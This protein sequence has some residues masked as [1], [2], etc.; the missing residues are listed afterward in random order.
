VDEVILVDDSDA[1]EM[2]RLLAD[3][4]GILVGI[5][6]GANVFGAVEVAKKYKGKKVVTVAPDGID[7]YMSMGLFE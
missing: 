2:V 1:F 7:K 4:E 3:K 6:S 5:S